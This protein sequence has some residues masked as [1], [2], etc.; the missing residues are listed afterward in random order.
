VYSYPSPIPDFASPNTD[1]EVAAG[2]AKT[3][4]VG[5]ML[6]LGKTLASRGILYYINRI[7]FLVLKQP[8]LEQAYHIS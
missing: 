7:G 8:Q 2:D 1:S 4:H 6:L 5:E 3:T